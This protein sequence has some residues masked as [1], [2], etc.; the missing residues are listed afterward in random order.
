VVPLLPL[1][2]AAALAVHLPVPVEPSPPRPGSPSLRM[3]SVTVL[4][5]TLAWLV[6]D[7]SNRS[8]TFTRALRALSAGGTPLVVGTPG[9]LRRLLPR[10]LRRHAPIAYA[11]ALHDHSDAPGGPRVQRIVVVVDVDAYRRLYQSDPAGLRMDLEVILAHEIA[12]HAAGW[13]RTGLLRSGCLDPDPL[14][15][16]T[17]PEATGCAVDEENAVRRELGVPARLTYGHLIYPS[18]RSHD[19]VLEAYARGELSSRQ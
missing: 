16:A 13:S 8:P 6:E 14:T 15:V 1:F 2:F 12:G 3:G 4:E 18:G 17:D 9:Q 11:A 19:A 10:E 7:L 5:P